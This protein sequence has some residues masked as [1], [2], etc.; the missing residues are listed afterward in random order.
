MEFDQ[1]RLG[2]ALCVE[3]DQARLGNALCVEF[4]QARLGLVLGTS[5]LEMCSVSTNAE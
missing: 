2:N 1:A 5:I 3:F 4:D